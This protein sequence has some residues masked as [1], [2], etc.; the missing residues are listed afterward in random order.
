MTA[1]LTTLL[2]NAGSEQPEVRRSAIP[3]LRATLGDEARD[4][5]LAM[6]TDESTLVIE[7]AANA[8]VTRDAESLDLTL[9]AW[10]TAEGID[11]EYIRAA[12][13]QLALDGTDLEA[14]LE[15]RLDTGN[16]AVRDAASQLLWIYRFRPTPEDRA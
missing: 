11:A 3:G 6:L 10:L 5:L 9:T 16:E 15:D 8:L 2:A 1:T 14:I 13:T 7:D 4:A 12:L